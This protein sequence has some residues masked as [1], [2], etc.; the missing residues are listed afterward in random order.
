M[1]SISKDLMERIENIER[2]CRDS[3][4]RTTLYA[5][6]VRKLAPIRY[7]YQM[8]DRDSDGLGIH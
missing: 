8:A 5:P 7:A 4:R 2:M 1:I 6:L 3:Y